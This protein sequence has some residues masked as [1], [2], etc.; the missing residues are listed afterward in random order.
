MLQNIRS[1][2]EKPV[3]N[4]G[5]DT[6]SNAGTFENLREVIN[7]MKEGYS[8][9]TIS[10]QNCI[11]LDGKYYKNDSQ[12]PLSMEIKISL[13]EEIDGTCSRLIL[14][15]KDTTERDM[16]AALESTTKFK[17]NILDSFSHEI[18]TPI[19]AVKA[20]LEA[21]SV[22]EDLPESIQQ[23]YILPAMRSA[24]MLYNIVNDIFDYLQ[25]SRS[26]L[27]IHC[28]NTNVVRLLESCYEIMRTNIEEKKIRFVFNVASNVSHLIRTDADRLRQV[29]INL[30]SN[31][32]RYT[33]EGE[34]VFSLEKEGN[35]LCIK[36][37]D[38]GRGMDED[39]KLRLTH[40]LSDV[41]KGEKVTQNSAGI[42]LGLMISHIIA[43]L[44]GPEGEGGL[45]FES[46]L[47]GGSI[48]SFL[49]ENKEMESSE[50]RLNKSHV[51]SKHGLRL[52]NVSSPKRKST[53]ESIKLNQ[54][55]IPSGLHKLSQWDLMSRPEEEIGSESQRGIY[56]SGVGTNISQCVPSRGLHSCLVSA[57]TVQSTSKKSLIKC[58]CPDVMIVDDEPMNILAFKLLIKRYKRKVD[59]ALSGEAAL[60]IINSRK[61]NPCCDLCRDHKLI[62]M[63]LNMPGMDGFETTKNMRN[64]YQI[65]KE[66]TAIVACTAYMEE[67]YK[68]RSLESGMDDFVNK[69]LTQMKVIEVLEKFNCL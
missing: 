43:S 67:L 28:Q 64:K 15:L 47:G 16:L 51:S 4:L 6:L 60:Q 55:N 66:D 9:N 11:I 35:Y 59:S 30:L 54:L 44:L 1:E 40:L 53:T 57:E 23:K 19:N 49:V 18:R 26:G 20:V 61:T 24:E 48:F 65:A 50:V 46:E 39:A 52:S 38:T 34:I 45:C 13:F 63:D 25:F 3:V 7:Y 22:D 68:K 32:I 37:S 14:I 8:D 29:V 56:Y 41:Y 42:G 36:I 31:A 17:D 27:T 2:S 33:H 69:P 58:Q 21:S 10:A 62:F 5:E 12:K